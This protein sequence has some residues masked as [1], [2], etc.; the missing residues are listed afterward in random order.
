[1][2]AHLQQG[3]FLRGEKNRQELVL[4]NTESSVLFWDIHKRANFIKILNKGGKRFP[5]IKLKSSHQLFIWKSLL[6]FVPLKP[7]RTPFYQQSLVRTHYVP[8]RPCLRLWGHSNEERCHLCFQGFTV[9]WGETADRY[10]TVCLGS[11]REGCRVLPGTQRRDPTPVW[12]LREH[13]GGV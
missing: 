10:N 8:G 3:V 13:L 5:S 11:T 1:M 6:G 7:H 9:R 4:E 2:H 12:G